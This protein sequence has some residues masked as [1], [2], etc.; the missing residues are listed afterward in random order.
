MYPVTHFH[1]LPLGAPVVYHRP[2]RPDNPLCLVVTALYDDPSVA[3]WTQRTALLLLAPGGFS[4]TVRP[5]HLRTPQGVP[6][7]TTGPHYTAARLAC[8]RNLQTADCYACPALSQSRAVALTPAGWPA[9]ERH[10]AAYR[11]AERAQE[12]CPEAVAGTYA[13]LGLA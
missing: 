9:C 3:R 4:L 7:G 1:Q 12:W 5:E 6:W 2:D 10:V 13:L 8:H 11:V